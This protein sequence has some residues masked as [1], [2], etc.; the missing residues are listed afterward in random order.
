MR[1]LL[2]TQCGLTVE[3][4]AELTPHGFRHVLVTAG[5]Q[6]ERQGHVARIGMGTLGHRELGS[7]M[8]DTYGNESG[9]S[10]LCT[11]HIILTAFRGGW[12]PAR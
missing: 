1:A 7:H 11:R 10:E 3:A 9:V 5:T 4:A 8:P 6:L 12:A 2:V